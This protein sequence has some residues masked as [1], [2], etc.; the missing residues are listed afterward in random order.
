M[1]RRWERGAGVAVLVAACA[2]AGDDAPADTDADSDAD[3]PAVVERRPFEL[4][5]FRFTAE[6]AIDAEGRV[7]RFTDTGDPRFSHV[8]VELL[9]DGG[10]PDVP[11]DDGACS[12]A[13]QPVT[14]Q[15]YPLDG[16]APAFPEEEAA[17]RTWLDAQ[18]LLP[19]F[20]L[21][22]GNFETGPILTADGDACPFALDWA[23]LNHEPGATFLRGADGA[24]GHL[25]VGLGTTLSPSLAAELR[26]EGASDAVLATMTSSTFRTPR[27]G[28]DGSFESTAV[29]AALRLDAVLDVVRDRVGVAEQLDADAF[30]A[31]DGRAA[32]ALYL[33]EG[34][35]TFAPP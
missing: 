22:A 25:Y 9:D 32:S 26:A 21:W 31:G 30:D 7:T 16:E 8:T 29:T 27:A 15:G 33:L 13:Y 35:V 14:Q 1:L 23:I 3:P 10:T 34:R 12:F 5:G 6:V 17:Y 2:P 18:G 24:L 28:P 4:T 11:D 19:A 20:G